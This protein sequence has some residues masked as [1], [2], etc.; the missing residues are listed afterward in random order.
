MSKQNEY[1]EEQEC[2]DTQEYIRAFEIIK[3]DMTHDQRRL[4]YAH[5][6]SPD[7]S[8]SIEE[9]KEHTQYETVIEAETQ[10]ALLGRALY[11]HLEFRFSVQGDVPERLQP[12][13]TLATPIYWTAGSVREWKMRPEVLSAL[14]YTEL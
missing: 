2:P 6:A 5:I 9:L 11:A 7:L 10:Y 3:K 14:S 12:I 13:I 4:L 1:A 8:A